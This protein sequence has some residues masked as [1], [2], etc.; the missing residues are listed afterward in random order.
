MSEKEY[1]STLIYD[2]SYKISM[3]AKPLRFR[4]D[5]IDGFVRNPDKEIRRL[6]LFDCGF[7][8]KLYDNI[9][10]LM[11][12]KMA[13]QLVLIIILEKLQLTHIILKLLKSIDF[14]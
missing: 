8:D 13:L 10:Y 1:E 7:F 3:G 5:K 2:I 12:K 9:K 11:S 6:V 4:F 14:S